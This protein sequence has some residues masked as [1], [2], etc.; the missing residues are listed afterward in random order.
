MFSIEQLEAFVTTVEQGSF[1][2][3]ARKLHK[4]QSA[5]SQHV[6]NIEIDCGFELFDRSSRYPKL[7]LH[8]QRLLPYAKASLIQHQ[9]LL[10]CAQQLEHTDFQDITL[11]VD[12]GI[13][14]TQLSAALTAVCERYPTLRFECLTASSIDIIALV[15]QQRATMGI[16]FNEVS[17]DDNIDF[18]GLGSVEFDVYV[19]SHHALAQE[20]VPHLDM[21]RLHRQIVI[22]SKS[23]E[24]S[25]FQHAHS[26]EVWFA[27][28]H[29]ILLELISSGFG[30]GM[31]PKHI[32]LPALESGKL[33]QLRS[34]FENLSWH[35]NIDV[36]QHQAVSHCPAHS[37]MRHQLRMLL[38]AEKQ[39]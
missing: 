25:S 24:M 12:E 33:I 14:M 3:A 10:N 36:I 28:S 7:T 34:Q 27:D 6:M 1:S 8:G 4:V 21:L 16:M 31:L 2:A 29:Y 18:E 20:T 35:A 32:A 11:A 30:W 37:F 23:S 26:P 17:L 15:K 38:N 22:R 39:S 9:R 13:P 5:I 19:A